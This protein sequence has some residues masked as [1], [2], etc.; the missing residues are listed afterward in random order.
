MKD[1]YHIHIPRSRYLP[2]VHGYRPNPK[3]AAPETEGLPLVIDGFDF[4][5]TE[6]TPAV[7]RRGQILV[8]TGA[9]LHRYAF[10]T[11]LS[12]NVPLSSR[13]F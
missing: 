8:H 10:S 13:K 12:T 6:P 7:A 9:M 4:L 3:T 1:S 11:M 5:N 2:R